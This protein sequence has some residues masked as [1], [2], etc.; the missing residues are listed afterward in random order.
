M[1]DEKLQVANELY[2]EI[3]D[4]QVEL[5]EVE[6]ILELTQTS[7]VGVYTY[8]LTIKEKYGIPRNYEITAS[9]V[10]LIMQT[11]LKELRKTLS[12]KQ[13]EFDKL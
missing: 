6:R 2:Q 11:R 1:T 5:V 12:A 7:E 8:N 9:E 13:K 4:L 3:T 10:E